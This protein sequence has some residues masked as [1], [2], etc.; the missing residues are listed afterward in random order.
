MSRPSRKELGLDSDGQ[1]IEPA[2]R[3]DNNWQQDDVKVRL[4]HT[5]ISILPSATRAGYEATFREA[6]GPWT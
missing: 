4:P 5:S 6:G 1:I 2:D 3:K